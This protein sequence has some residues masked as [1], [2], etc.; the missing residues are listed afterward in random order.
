MGGRVAGKVS[1]SWGV[2][3]GWIYRDNDH[4]VACVVALLSNN[5]GVEDLFSI[6]GDILKFGS[7]GSPAV[8][9][10]WCSALTS[11]STR[12]INNI[13]LRHLHTNR[14]LPEIGMST[15]NNGGEQLISHVLASGGLILANKVNILA[16]HTV[17][18]L[19]K[20][21]T[22]AKHLADMVG[23]D[24]IINDDFKLVPCILRS[25]NEK[26]KWVCAG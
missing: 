26:A 15:R 3:V 18:V 16:S 24:K 17:G 6:D 7:K 12:R 21:G 8:W 5:G 20:V 1:K 19:L 10:N 4:R 13:L 22:G 9:G 2:G 14:M 23:V 11:V 25:L